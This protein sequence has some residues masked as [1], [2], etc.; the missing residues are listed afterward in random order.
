ML[1]RSILL[2]GRDVGF[3]LF[4]ILTSKIKKTVKWLMLLEDTSIR[5]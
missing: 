1:F 2:E 4:T 5:K 3:V